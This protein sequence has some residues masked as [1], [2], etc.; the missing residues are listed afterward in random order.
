MDALSQWASVLTPVAV[1]MAWV[2]TMAPLKFNDLMGCSEGENIIH[3][4]EELH[5]G[6]DKE[7]KCGVLELRKICPSPLGVR[8]HHTCFTRRADMCLPPPNEHVADTIRRMGHWPDCEWLTRLWHL[9][10]RE[11]DLF[12]E[13]GAN[14][15][16][17]TL[18]MLL[19]TN[20]TVV[21]I[22]PNPAN[23]FYLTSTLAMAAHANPAIAQRVVVLP[24]GASSYSRTSRM[25]LRGGGSAV[26]APRRA[27]NFNDE[28]AVGTKESEATTIT[29]H[30][31]DELIPT[32]TASHLLKADVQGLECEVLRG[33]ARNLPLISAAAVELDPR[34]LRSNGCDAPTIL[35]L[36]CKHGLNSSVARTM[37]E[38]TAFAHRC[39]VPRCEKLKD[40][41]QC[42]LPPYG[43]DDPDS[44][45]GC[46]AVPAYQ[47]HWHRKN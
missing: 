1:S 10:A 34:L 41:V 44:G 16:A 46:R 12:V 43:R 21:A 30:R 39:G 29:V 31:L 27:R 3:G 14:I 18:E 22:E 33:A 6:C 5:P 13:V 42:R 15:G 24:V 45:A 36:L 20:A 28:A 35:R 8:Q 2:P 7:Y 32:Q 38:H 40:G 23:L 19:S 4:T 26:D 17:C 11:Q 37:S 47:V 9:K 25:T